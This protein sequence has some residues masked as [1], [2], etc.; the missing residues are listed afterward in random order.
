MHMGMQNKMSKFTSNSKPRS[1]LNK[2]DN[3]NSLRENM[4]RLAEGQMVDII[5]CGELQNDMF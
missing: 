5:Q 4:D 2:L 3:C 1:M